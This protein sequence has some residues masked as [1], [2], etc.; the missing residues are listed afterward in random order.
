M[1]VDLTCAE[2]VGALTEFMES[3]VTPALRAR[4]ELHLE[5]CR[6]CGSIYDGV[7]NVSRLVADGRVLELP[8]GFS[9]RL[10]QRLVRLQ[11][12]RG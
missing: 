4:I 8:A 11:R 10:Q 6:H 1:Y 3:E 5:G 9:A 2:V 12:H 7:H